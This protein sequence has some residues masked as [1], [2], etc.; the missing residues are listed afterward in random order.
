MGLIPSNA[1]ILLIMCFCL[2]SFSSH[3][4]TYK[5]STQIMLAIKSRVILYLLDDSD[6]IICDIVLLIQIEG[7]H[8]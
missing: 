6:V 5:F 4:H 1:E 7:M 3:S 2:L 8:F